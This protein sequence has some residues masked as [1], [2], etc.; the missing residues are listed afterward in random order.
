MGRQTENRSPVDKEATSGIIVL[1]VLVDCKGEAVVSSGEA[2]LEGV[3]EGEEMGEKVTTGLVAISNPEGV[4]G[5]KSS[6]GPEGIEK[7]SSQGG[8]IECTAA[9]EKYSEQI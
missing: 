4:K 9:L 1:G 3:L 2:V 7:Q 8:R 6:S 5:W